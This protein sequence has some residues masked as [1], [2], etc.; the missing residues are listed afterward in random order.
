MSSVAKNHRGP[1]LKGWRILVRNLKFETKE[2]DIR[3]LAGKF[4]EILEINLPKGRD[5]RFPNSCAGFCFIQFK[6]RMDAETAKKELNFKKFNGRKIS[7]DWTMNKDDWRI[8]NMKKI[9]K[10]QK[11][12]KTSLLMLK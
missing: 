10:M 4:G 5:K 9:Q 8:V 7:L 11:K 3:K 1:G 12:L 6:R 2:E